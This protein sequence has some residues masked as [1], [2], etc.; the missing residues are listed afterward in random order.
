[1]RPQNPRSSRPNARRSFGTSGPRPIRP[2]GRRYPSSS[3]RR[4]SRSHELRHLGD[5]AS[6]DHRPS[7]LEIQ[8]TF[9][10]M[11]VRAVAPRDPG[12]SAHRACRP[13]DQRCLGAED[14]ANHRPDAPKIRSTSAGSIPGAWEPSP[15]W[16]EIPPPRIA[17][18]RWHLGP[19]A[20]PGP[21]SEAPR[22]RR[23]FAP[24]AQGA[25]GPRH[26]GSYALT[27][28]GRS[29]PMARWFDA[30]TSSRSKAPRADERA[31]TAWPQGQGRSVVR[32]IA[33]VNLKGGSGKTTTALSLAV[34]AAGR[35]RRVLLIDADPQA[36][37]SLTLLDGAAAEEPTLGHVLLDQ[38]EVVESIRPSRVKRVEHP[39]RRRSAGRR[40]PLARRAARPRAAVAL[41]P[42]RRR[43]QL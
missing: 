36:N 9:D 4:P 29:V 8:G 40:R 2:E 11:L 43:G 33:V 12:S 17:Q 30:P 25:P 22:P 3:E 18:G 37:A 23:W 26:N 1:M 38:A 10:P 13:R 5:E 42:A 31:E 19:E 35:K 7:A 14:L 28:P 34:G 6:L 21:Q 20:P 41:G 27:V 24:T 39:A 15:S 32:T 16:A